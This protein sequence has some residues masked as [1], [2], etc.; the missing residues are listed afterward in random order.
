LPTK[1]IIL[2]EAIAPI[3]AEFEVMA[4]DAEEAFN[5]LQQGKSIQL[6]QK[7]NVNLL[8][9]IKKKVTIKEYNTSMI[10]L[11]KNM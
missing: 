4:N 9:M 6:R 8:K 11:I 7:P 5:L 10:K 3:Q 2:V 1:Y